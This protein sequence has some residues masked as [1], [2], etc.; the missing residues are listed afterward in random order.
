MVS[1]W[2][3]KANLSSAKAAFEYK[4]HHL[5]TRSLKECIEIVQSF[6]NLIHGATR[7]ALK[8]EINKIVHES[9]L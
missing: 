4:S 5:D 7:Q 1:N 2:L 9:P 6:E 3:Q 8:I